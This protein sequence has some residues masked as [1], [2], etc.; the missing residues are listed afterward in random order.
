MVVNVARLRIVLG[1]GVIGIGIAL[2]SLGFLGRQSSLLAAA[3]SMKSDDAQAWKKLVSDEHFKAMLENQKAEI[4]KSMKSNGTF[5]RA[6]KKL[7]GAGQIIAVLANVQAFRSEGEDV[8]KASALRAA[9]LQLAKAA[10]DKN[11][12]AAKKAVE[13]IAAYP[14]TIAPADDDKTKWTDLVKIGA[15]MH[16]V[17]TIDAETKTAVAVAKPADF[18]K[19]A[20]AAES[21]ARLLACLSVIS[22]DYEE[23]DDWKQ[24]CDEMRQGSVELAETFAKKNQA[25]SKAAR[26][27]LLKTCKA[28]H[29]VYRP[30]QN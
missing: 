24:W 14:A 7:E 21:Q 9:G 5:R 4:D 2:A 1:L 30:D 20:A 25:A 28:C 22:R 13:Q 19:V 15:V 3:E 10:A 6:L 11:F 29:D 23:S 18:K 27:E 17:S 16:G 12:D 26:D 8:K